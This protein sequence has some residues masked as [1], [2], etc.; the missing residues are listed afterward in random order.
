MSNKIKFRDALLSHNFGSMIPQLGEDQKIIF[1][2]IAEHIS[3]FLDL[4]AD[5]YVQILHYVT[6][7]W[8]QEG[9]IT[10]EYFQTA[11]PQERLQ[12]AIK[13]LD[14]VHQFLLPFL[15][16]PEDDQE[17]RERLEKSVTFYFKT[18]ASR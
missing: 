14:A 8:E 3:Q 6:R 9:S 7:Q 18:F 16:N 4:Q 13:F 5:L 10:F 15:K 2:E 12:V 11:T 1:V 17:L